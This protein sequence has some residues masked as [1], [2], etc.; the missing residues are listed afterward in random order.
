MQPEN[1][2]NND[3]Q[4]QPQ[5]P[6]PQPQQTSNNEI[7]QNQA[8]AQ[9]LAG[10]AVIPASQQQTPQTQENPQIFQQTPQQPITP[11]PNAKGS[12]KAVF[13]VLAAIVLLL[14]VVASVFF[15]FVLNKKENYGTK[16]SITTA[17]PSYNI[18][19]PAP[20]KKV[21]DK[22]KASLGL[23]Q[24]FKADFGGNGKLKL[25]DEGLYAKFKDQNSKKPPEA[26]LYYAFVDFSSFKKG[27]ESINEL[28]RKS[29][30]EDLVRTEEQFLQEVREEIQKDTSGLASAIKSSSD[31]KQSVVLQDI[32]NPVKV[33]NGI[34]MDVSGE[35]KENK[36]K[37]V[38]K[39]AVYL[40]DNWNL[41]TV[42][43]I[44]EQELW[45]NNK[46]SFEDIFKS[47]NGDKDAQ[48]TKQTLLS[49][50]M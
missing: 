44:A 41:V 30:R 13:F 20:L 25:K 28:A 24:D 39:L 48:V 15:F 8:P 36:Q 1:Q 17:V 29:G 23:S 6:E 49:K 12:K 3:I 35:L 9:P 21:E 16:Q 26:V 50:L 34:E 2:L 47:L 32:N 11:A 43:A 45:N 22:D 33:A 14:I 38:G 19:A 46:Q 42:I 31:D 27:I 40:D 4:P 10:P 18:S 7:S 37:I 5:Q